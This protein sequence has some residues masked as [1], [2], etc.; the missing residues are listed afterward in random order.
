MIGSRRLH[1]GRVES[2]ASEEV[3]EVSK[4]RCLRYLLVGECAVAYQD[5]PGHVIFALKLSLSETAGG[6]FSAVVN[7]VLREYGKPC[8]DDC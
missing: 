3:E 5:G 1:V 6:Q 8:T 4:V 7:C 2:G